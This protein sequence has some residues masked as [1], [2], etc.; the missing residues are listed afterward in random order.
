MRFEA[1]TG[2]PRKQ[3]G[4]ERRARGFKRSS[5]QDRKGDRDR[6]RTESHERAHL[7]DEADQDVAIVDPRT[8]RDRTRRKYSGKNRQG[9]TQDRYGLGVTQLRRVRLKMRNA[10]A[11]NIDRRKPEG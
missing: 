6:R 11:N 3:N 4:A 8:R 7:S 5:A 10:Q 2:E 9:R 1:G